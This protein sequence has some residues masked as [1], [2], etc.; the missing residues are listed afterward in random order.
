MKIQGNH[1]YADK[2]PMASD[3]ELAELAESIAAVGLINPVVLTPGGLVLDGRNRLKA[4][5]VAGVEPTFTTRDGDDDDYKEFVIGV[6]TTGRRESMTVQIAAAA[7]ALILGNEKRINGQWR[8]GS[9]PVSTESRTNTWQDAIRQAGLVL[10]I[11]GPAYLEAVRDGDATL[12]ASYE[13]ARN[14][15]QRQEEAEAQRLRDIAERESEEAA[16]RELFATDPDAKAYMAERDP[17]GAQDPVVLRTAFERANEEA[18]RK[19]REQER[20]EARK[21]KEADEAYSRAALRLQNF[22]WGYGQAKNL[23]TNPDR[24]HILAKL[25]DEERHQFTTIEKE[26]SW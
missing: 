5:E 4:C 10:D 8:R 7:T 12:N 21:K 25:T 14:E 1:P 16:A 13:K 15:K 24:E 11:L 17:D 22:L 20:E 19:R 9:V 26:L 3:D 6:N 18:W 23:S 2:F